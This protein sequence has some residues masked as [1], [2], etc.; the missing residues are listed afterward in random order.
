MTIYPVT[1]TP[2]N[3]SHMLTDSNV[4][5]GHKTILGVQ[6]CRVSWNTMNTVCGCIHIYTYNC[7]DYILIIISILVMQLSSQPYKNNYLTLSNNYKQSQCITWVLAT[8]AKRKILIPKLQSLLYCS[9]SF[10]ASAYSECRSA[11]C[12][13]SCTWLKQPPV[14]IQA[15]G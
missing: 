11:D 5:K 3:F 7:E 13:N 10:S 15:E 1:S 4:K 2:E 12:A 9:Q 8:H 14:S 6:R